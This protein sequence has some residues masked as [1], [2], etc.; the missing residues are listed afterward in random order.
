VRKIQN[1]ERNG[2]LLAETFKVL[3]GSLLLQHHIFISEAVVEQTAR[4]VE[5][6]T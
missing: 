6:A 5:E 2:S 1:I 4:V 3:L